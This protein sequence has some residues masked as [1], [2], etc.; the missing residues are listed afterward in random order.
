MKKF[1]IALLTIFAVLAVA[2]PLFAQDDL[3]PM[4]TGTGVNV[5]SG[6]GIEYS[7]RGGLIRGSLT[8]TGRNDFDTTRVCNGLTAQ[9][10]DMWLQVDYNGVEGWVAYCAVN[11]NTDLITVPVT[12]AGFPVLINDINYATT[13]SA[14]P[15]GARPEKFVFGATRA[16]VNMRTGS[17]LDNNIIRELRGNET[18][19]VTDHNAD[20]SWVKVQVDGQSGWVARYLIALP[21]DWQTTFVEQES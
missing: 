10:L 15:L 8:I 6:P 18:V 17:G 21:Q 13:P 7:L 14:L 9:D 4:A 19:Y 16:R 20:Y 11:V 3:T 2:L 12:N 5:R 1:G